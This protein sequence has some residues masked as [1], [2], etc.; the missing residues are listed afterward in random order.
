LPHQLAS[1]GLGKDRGFE[2]IEQRASARGFGFE[3][4]GASECLLNQFKQIPL[5]IC[6]RNWNNGSREASLT[7]MDNVDPLRI[8]NESATSR[9]KQQGISDTK[10]QSG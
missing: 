7:N 5:L 8:G 6:R 2:A 10:P 4:V 1:E 3:S 9:D